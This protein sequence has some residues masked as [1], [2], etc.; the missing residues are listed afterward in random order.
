[1]RAEKFLATMLRDWGVT[2]WLVEGRSDESVFI[3]ELFSLP[4]ELVVVVMVLGLVILHD[5]RQGLQAGR[6]EGPL[7]PPRTWSIVAIVL[8]GL[9]LIVALES[10][11]GLGRPPADLHAIEMGP[12]GFPSGHA[13]AATICW[14]G[15]AWWYFDGTPGARIAAVTAIVTFVGFG[16]LMLGV[17][18]LIDVLAGIGFGVVYLALA[19]RGV[20]GNPGRAFLLAIG[21]AAVAV[22]ASVADTRSIAAFLAVIAGKVTYQVS[23]HPRVRARGRQ[24]G[25]RLSRALTSRK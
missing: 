12:Y 2:R 19:D 10:L 16:Q 25:Q 14:G 8:G 24:A 18:Y 17:H 23:E 13:M 7:C 6:A 1:M 15:L 3:F 21:L 20:L 4:G 22:V 5:I 11:F 9:A